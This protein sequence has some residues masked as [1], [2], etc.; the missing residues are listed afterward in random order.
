MAGTEKSTTGRLILAFFSFFQ[1]FDEIE[2]TKIK[3]KRFGGST[4]SLRRF[5]VSN[6]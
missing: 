1:G 6:W 5:E 2:K 3:D 4:F